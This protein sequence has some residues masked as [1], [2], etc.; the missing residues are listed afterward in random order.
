MA[1]AAPRRVKSK[2]TRK[3]IF[4]AAAAILKERGEDYLTIANICE[5]AGISKGTFFYHFNSKDDLMLYY[6]Q[7]ALDDYIISSKHVEEAGD[8]IYLKVLYLYED[9]LAYCE[10]AGIDFVSS[11]YTPKNKALDARRGMMSA[12]DAMNLT[13][14]E[15]AE[16]FARAQEKGYVR[17]DWSVE[18]LSLDCCSVVKGVVFEWCLSDGTID[19][20]AHLRHMLYAYFQNVLTDAYRSDFPHDEPPVG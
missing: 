10:D 16:G 1:G 14:R 9:Y 5:Q 15:C 4:E 8:D 19:Q 11:Y 13:L 17:S 18:D 12:P 2:Q 20:Y 3:K 7:E 6:L